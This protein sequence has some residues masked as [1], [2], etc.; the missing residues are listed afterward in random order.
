LNLSL[1]YTGVQQRLGFVNAIITLTSPDSFTSR[2]ILARQLFE[3]VKDKQA[4][5]LKNYRSSTGAISAKT[6]GDIV[7][8]ATSSPLELLFPSTFSW[9]PEARLLEHLISDE[10]Y[11]AFQGVSPYNP[12]EITL[13]ERF[14]FLYKFLINDGVAFVHLMNG[15]KDAKTWSRKEAA[16]LLQEAYQL[17]GQRRK[18]SAQTSSEYAKANEILKLAERMKN[19]REGVV[20]T[21]EL[22]VTPRLEV[23]V[24]LYIIDKPENEKNSYAYCRNEFS[25]RFTEKFKDIDED[26]QSINSDFF[27]RCAYLYKL[28]AKPASDEEI[29]QMIV[30]NFQYVTAAYG[31]AGIDEVCLLVAIKALASAPAKIVEINKARE[32]LIDYQKK[33]QDHIKLHVDT[34]GR[35]RYFSLSKDFLTTTVS[36]FKKF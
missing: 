27:E 1:F 15:L 35:I 32:V 28:N 8:W 16:L 2:E 29:F 10:E 17:Y 24:D 23:L 3:C 12:L 20:G 13:P 19:A 9:R 7:D 5:W 21:K 31:L 36:T 34:R 11:D 18:R 14:F 22:R 26:T 6:A 33:Y 4:T 25:I 30:N